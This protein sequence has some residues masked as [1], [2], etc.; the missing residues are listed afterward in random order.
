MTAAVYHGV[1]D[2]RI[3]QLPDVRP[4]PGQVKLKVAHNGSCGSDLHEYFAGAAL[5][6]RDP[7]PLTGASIPIVLGH[8][9]AG[10]VVEAGSGVDT[11]RVGDRVAVRQAIRLRLGVEIWRHS[12]RTTWWIQRMANYLDCVRTSAASSAHRR[13]STRPVVAQ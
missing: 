11:P 7:H 3:E 2:V 1:R 12:E 8:E 10:T 13:C 5:I 6:P 4:G 9:F